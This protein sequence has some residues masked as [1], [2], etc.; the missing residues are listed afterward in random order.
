MPLSPK[1]LKILAFPYSRYQ[2][3]ICDGS[4]RSG[5]TSTMTVSFVDWMMREYDRH[6]FIV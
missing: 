1:Q 6:H 3:L 5:K 4:I 2:T